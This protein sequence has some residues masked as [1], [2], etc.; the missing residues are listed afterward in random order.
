M[1]HGLNGTESGGV[2]GSRAWFYSALLVLAWGLAGFPVQAIILFSTGDP[3]FNTS[4]PTGSLT[5]S[6]WQFQGTWG[7][8]LGTPLAASYFITAKHVGGMV[9]DP[10][11]YQGQ[12]YVTLASYEDP[13]SDLKIWRVC[14]R[15]GSFAPLW[16]NLSEV[17]QAMVV[18]GR[19]TQRG[20]EVRVSGQLKGWRWG[21]YDQVQ[22][23]GENVVTDIA[24][25]GSGIGDLLQAAF[26]ADGG[27]N[28]AH[29]SVGDSGGAVFIQD[30]SVWKIAGINYSV[31]GP[32][33]TNT[34]GAGFEAAIFDEGGL[35]TGGDGSWFARRN[36]R[37]D[38]PG[39]L[40]ATRISTRISWIDGILSQ[41]APPD[42][43]PT[44]EAASAVTGP[45][46][47]DSSA[48]ANA[49]ARTITLPNRGQNREFFRLGGC[50]AWR[51]TSI[52]RAGAD[53]LLSYGD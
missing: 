52:A 9:G 5:N 2:R 39:A 30:G 7:S 43:A 13:D 42:P 6:G 15:F 1:I 3:S 38:R 50:T 36:S 35:Y 53:I 11:L 37:E 48:M 40:Y 28:E 27:P 46:V 10:F 45:Y 51:I 24:P 44:V 21:T 41:T 34:I 16:T 49:E 8:Y 22:R 4:Q 12:S 32:Y 17:G 31:D 47:A 33:N 20:D 19:G 25:G 29:L 18:F 26:N 14:G 23:W